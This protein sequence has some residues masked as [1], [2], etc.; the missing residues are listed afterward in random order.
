MFQSE[1]NPKAVARVV[2]RWRLCGSVLEEDGRAPVGSARDDGTMV[3]RL[4]GRSGFEI[5]GPRDGEKGN[6]DM[7]V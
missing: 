7:G 5:P 1:T 2:E 4:V 3:P 6:S